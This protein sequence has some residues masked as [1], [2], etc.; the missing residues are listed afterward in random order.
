MA[1][2]YSF[3]NS[4]IRCK[5]EDAGIVMCGDEDNKIAN[6]WIEYYISGQDD[7]FYATERLLELAYTEPSRAWTIIKLI[8]HVSIDDPYWLEFVDSVLAAGPI[9]DLLAANGRDFVRL[10]VEEAK[11][12]GRLLKQ[13]ELIYDGRVEEEVLRKIRSLK[14]NV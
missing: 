10:F 1:I 8:N 14:N 4:D 13:L 9:E 2:N 12:N 11:S 6:D 7:C 3:A 5:L